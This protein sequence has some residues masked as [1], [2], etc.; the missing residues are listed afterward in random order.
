LGDDDQSVGEL[1]PRV[2]ITVLA[3]AFPAWLLLGAVVV[4][5]R[6][7]YDRA[8]RQRSSHALAV[9]EAR[10]LVRLAGGRPRTDWGRWRKI[11]A[12]TRLTQAHHQAAPRL[13]RRAL[14][15]R[16][17]VVAAAAIR[18]LGDLGDHWAIELLLAAMRD[19]QAPRS[20]I[21]A[22][23]ER[24]APRPGARLLALLGDPDP[25]VRFWGATLLAPYPDLGQSSLVGLTRDGDA[26]VRAAAV[27]TLGDRGGPGVAEATLA[28]LEDPAWF[29]RV[30]A[31]RSAGHVLGVAAAPAL[32][33]L[34][35]DSRWWVRT[36]AKDALRGIGAEA[37]PSLLPVLSDV[38]A[39]ARNGAAE[40]LQDIGFVDELALER[41][42]SPLLERIYAAGG[43]R[44]RAAAEHRALDRRSPEEARAA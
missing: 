7:R 12:L 23:L 20:R 18:A 38:D 33:R 19:G 21:A 11:S 9:H 36:A 32:T 22:Q 27:E 15:D 14:A 30:H 6:L 24:L 40:I 31:A 13:V 42:D 8:M 43:E 17:P 37:V 16:D 41:P 2:A 39:F 44:L 3:V 29:V 10:R 35:A 4:M 34:L 1:V 5:G 25:V 26:N 28:L